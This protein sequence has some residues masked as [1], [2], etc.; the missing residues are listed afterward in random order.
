MRRLLWKPP[1]AWE[2]EVW[3]VVCSPRLSPLKIL[4][5]LQTF[6]LAVPCF[7]EPQDI[8]VGRG[9][10]LGPAWDGEE[11]SHLYGRTKEPRG[12]QL[13]RRGSEIYF[14]ILPISLDSELSSRPSP[15]LKT[16]SLPAAMLEMTQ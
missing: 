8:E 7:P 14:E 16:S 5:R 15:L 10:D 6:A 9:Q 4:Q 13:G 12:P 1:D 2:L 3:S 11:E